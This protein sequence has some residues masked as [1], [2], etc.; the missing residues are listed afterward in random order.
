MI[1]KLGTC[2]IVHW[3]PFWGQSNHY[4]KRYCHFSTGSHQ[5][6]QVWKGWK[7]LILAHKLNF[8]DDFHSV[9]STNYHEFWFDDLVQFTRFHMSYQP[10]ILINFWAQ[11][12]F[13]PREQQKIRGLPV[14]VKLQETATSNLKTAIIRWFFGILVWFFQWFLIG[15]VWSQVHTFI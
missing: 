13:F 3:I 11:Y 4:S 6:F 5:N 8:D 9:Y 10:N 12:D 7:H 2:L 15:Y 1:C 14:W